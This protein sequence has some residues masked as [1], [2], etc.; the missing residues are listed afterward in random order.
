MLEA[1]AVTERLDGQTSL[2]AI[3][4]PAQ[5]VASGPD[6]S[7]DALE[8]RLVAEDVEVRRLPIGLAAHSSMMDPMVGPF[9]ALVE[10]TPRGTLRIPMVSTATGDWAT[11]DGMADP[12]RR[13][14]FGFVMNRMG[15]GMT[16]GQTGY[17]VLQAF[18][19]AL[20][21]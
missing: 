7:I 15:S 4:A 19:E 20:G 3:N 5:V 9:R 6:A 14:G 12:D 1:E 17:A 10:K 11:P 21:R 8:A 13:V 16:G 2:A 18:F